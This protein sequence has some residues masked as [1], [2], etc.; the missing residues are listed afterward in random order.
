VGYF[1]EGARLQ[2]KG[3]DRVKVMKRF[4]G[5][6]QGGANSGRDQEKVN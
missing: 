6:I 4:G 1:S 2:R 5:G 3:R